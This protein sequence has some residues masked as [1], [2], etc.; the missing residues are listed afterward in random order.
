MEIEID[1]A[2]PKIQVCVRK[3]PFTHKEYLLKE[4]EIVHVLSSE[5]I[6]IHEQKSIK[7]NKSRQYKIH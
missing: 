4:Q 1:H 2:S 7:Y 5:E 3:R 6:T